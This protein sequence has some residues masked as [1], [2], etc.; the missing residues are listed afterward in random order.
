MKI[1][2][3]LGAM[4]GDRKNPFVE[5]GKQHGLSFEGRADFHQQP[6]ESRLVIERIR[7]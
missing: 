2:F 6:D 7:T 5:T 1:L 3:E 4:A